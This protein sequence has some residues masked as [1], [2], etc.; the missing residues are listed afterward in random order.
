MS[1]APVE[2]TIPR[3][4]AAVRHRFSLVGG[5]AVAPGAG[6]LFRLPA[7]PRL[8]HR[9]SDHG[10]VRDLARSRARLRR[11]RHARHAAFFGAGAYAVACWPRMKS[12]PSRS[13]AL[14]SPPWS[15]ARS[16]L[17]PACAA[18]HHRPDLAD[19]DACTMG[20]LEEIANM[21]ADV[22]AASTAT[23]ACR[24]SRCSA[25]SSSTRSIPTRSISTC[26]ACCCLLRVRAHAGYSPYGHSLT[27]IRHPREHAR[28]NAVG[29]PVRK[30]LIV[31]YTISPP[32]PASPARCG[33][34]PT[35]M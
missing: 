4:G 33:R 11:Y 7:L 2:T 12:G 15:R 21:A 13:R 5:A 25:S 20:L 24:S 31:C 3:T 19:A 10:A 23:T 8:R 35:P 34:R 1:V 6:V 30:R 18:S 26:S 27:L 29:A 9:A 32:S 17:H 28:M 16:D 22:T 14:S